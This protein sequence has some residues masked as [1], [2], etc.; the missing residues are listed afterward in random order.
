[1]ILCVLTEAKIA[2]NTY[3]YL[4]GICYCNPSTV[5]VYRDDNTPD[6]N[7]LAGKEK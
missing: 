2:V 4:H 3:M 5:P 1:M 7:I 6:M